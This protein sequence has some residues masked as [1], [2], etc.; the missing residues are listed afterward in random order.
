MFSGIPIPLQPCFTKIDKYLVVSLQSR[1][2]KSLVK[3]YGKSETS[4]LDNEDFLAC[5][6][7]LPKGKEMLS[8]AYSNVPVKFR[9]FYEQISSA[10][11]MLPMALPPDSELP[12][13]LTL[14]PTS[15]CITKHLFS[16]ISASYREGTGYKMVGYGPVGGELTRILLVPAL[17]GGAAAALFYVI[18][19]KEEMKPLPG[20]PEEEIVAAEKKTR[21]KSDLVLKAR[22]DLGTLAGGCFA[23]YVEKGEYPD[24]LTDLLVPTE[25]F[26]GGFYPPKKIPNDPWN[27]PYHYKKTTD[28]KHRFM[29]WSCGPNGI[30]EDG[31]GDDIV[32]IK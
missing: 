19:L 21:G 31:G 13:D 14:L 29:I 4:I 20:E 17:A 16:S 10:I 32:K 30:D 8:I 15:E 5:Y 7:R 25:A 27:N 12:V 22:K 9:A 3:T 18:P 28:G 1:D 24:R 6:G 23:Y 26:P 11:Q 2:L